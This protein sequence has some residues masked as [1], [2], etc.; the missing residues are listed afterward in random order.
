MISCMLY[1]CPLYCGIKVIGSSFSRMKETLANRFTFMFAKVMPW[2]K[3]GLNPKFAWP[4]R[5]AWIQQN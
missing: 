5:T 2:L 4:N 3:S 1:A